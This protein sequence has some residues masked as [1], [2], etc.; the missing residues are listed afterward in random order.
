MRFI[1]EIRNKKKFKGSTFW[2]IGT[3]RNLDFFPDN[4]F[5]DK[6][7]IAVNIAWKVF[8]KSTFFVMADLVMLNAVKKERPDYLA[9]CFTPL[10]Y[11]DWFAISSK[12]E[13]ISRNWEKW[14]LKPI[15]IRLDM[16]RAGIEVVL[17]RVPDFKSTAK[18]IVDNVT[19]C[20]VTMVHSSAHIGIY[21]AAILGAKKI[22]LVASSYSF[23]KVENHS[24]RKGL[25]VYQQIDA[26]IEN[27]FYRS[28]IFRRQ[29][30]CR[31][32]ADFRKHKIEIIEYRFDEEKRIF[33]FKKITRETVRTLE[34][35]KRFDF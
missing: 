34:K 19:P 35:Y 8:P 4:F 12:P 5:Y 10:L 14:R 28:L 1:E 18:A 11:D 6:F 22:V 25:E 32:V 27:Q 23:N 26:Q 16:P 30:L 31:L 2:I 7:S 3:D 15:Y 33:E 13:D 9:K 29:E 24:H 21:A 17:S 20:K